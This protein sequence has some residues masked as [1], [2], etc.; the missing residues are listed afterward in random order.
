MKQRLKKEKYYINLSYSFKQ[1][2]LKSK[3]IIKVKSDEELYIVIKDK[4]TDNEIS[5]INPFTLLKTKAI[6]CK[7]YVNKYIVLIKKQKAFNYFI[8]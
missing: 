5:D 1:I 4:Q 2:N 3:T 7:R 6:R 8:N